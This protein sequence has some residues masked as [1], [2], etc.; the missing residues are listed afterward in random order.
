[1]YNLICC[2][3]QSVYIS[4][5]MKPSP[6]SDNGHVHHLTNLLT[7]FYSTSSLSLTFSLP[8]QPLKCLLSLQIDLHF[9]EFCIEVRGQ[10]AKNK[11][12]VYPLLFP[13]ISLF[14][15]DSAGVFMGDPAQIKPIPSPYR[16]LTSPSS[17]QR[18]VQVY[19]GIC[20]FNLSFFPFK[21]VF[22]VTKHLPGCAS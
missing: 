17:L 8:V 21:N 3:Y 2:L 15:R 11:A 20:A 13:F 1:M 9:L 18:N 12:S 10:T 19:T 22:Q 7:T 4:I 16:N 6:Q 14:P 5:S